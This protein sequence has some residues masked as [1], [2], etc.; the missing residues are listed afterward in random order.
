MAAISNYNNNIQFYSVGGDRHNREKRTCLLEKLVKVNLHN[1]AKEDP[2]YEDGKFFIPNHIP[3]QY[4]N[5]TFKKIYLQERDIIILIGHIQTHEFIEMIENKVKNMNQRELDSFVRNLDV[6]VQGPGFNCEQKLLD[7]LKDRNITVK[8]ISQENCPSFNSEEWKELLDLYPPE[9]K[10][11]RDF[12]VGGFWLSRNIRFTHNRR[13]GIP[14]ITSAFYNQWGLNEIVNPNNNL[15]PSE[16]LIVFESHIWNQTKEFLSPNILRAIGTDFDQFFESLD[17]NE[18]VEETWSKIYGFYNHYNDYF[19]TH[20]NEFY[21]SF[22]KAIIMNISSIGNKLSK[23]EIQDTGITFMRGCQSTGIKEY[24]SFVTH[25]ALTGSNPTKDQH[26]NMIKACLKYN[27][28]RRNNIG[29][30]VLLYDSKILEFIEKVRNCIGDRRIICM[31]DLGLDPQ[32]DDWLAIEM[33][34]TVFVRTI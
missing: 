20:K 7:Y 3:E 21:P 13:N 5:A 2:S 32:C 10:Q 4:V 33:L 31:H 29:E 26:Y 18:S 12:Q 19:Q 15:K 14:F 27:N 1:Y 22:T 28:F 24:D 30:Q 34:M 17:S 8:N 16:N 9:L 6:W 11:M 23:L 25:I